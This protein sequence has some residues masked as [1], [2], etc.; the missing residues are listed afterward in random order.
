MSADP[1]VSANLHPL[2]ETLCTVLSRLPALSAGQR[3]RIAGLKGAARAFFVARCLQELPRPTVCVLDSDQTAEAFADDLR[4]FLGH[5][6]KTHQ[7]EQ[8]E[9]QPDQSDSTQ[10]VGKNLHLYPAWDVPAF[11]GLSPSS[12][13]VAAQVEGL[14]FLLS[15]TTPVLVTSIE[16]LTQ[17]VMP[18]EEFI[19]A[20]QRLGLGQDVSL[21][22]LVA[23]LLE[24]GYR[25]VPLVEEKGELSVRVQRGSRN[26]NRSVSSSR[27]RQQDHVQETRRVPWKPA[28]TST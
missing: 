17:R 15:V 8:E 21:S 6:D 12:D 9:K 4:L 5:T 16:A 24:W 28:P 10:G 13:V 1:P 14:Y 7:Q 18:Q 2:S 3:V 25:R 19:G 27:I 20:T 11:E 26:Q 23:S 22:D